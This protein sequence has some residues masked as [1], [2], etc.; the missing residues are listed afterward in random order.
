MKDFGK[1][2]I[3]AGGPSSERDISIESGKAVHRVLKAGGFDTVFIDARGTLEH[4]ISRSNADIVFI[5]LHGAF[6]EDGTVQKILDRIGMPYTGSGPDASELAMDKEASRKVFQDK[7]IN[8]PRYKV[9]KRGQRIDIGDLKLPL[10]V[11]PRREGSSIGLST[12]FD[13]K[14]L[15]QAAEKAF[16]YDEKILIEEFI[17]GR[18]L[19]V[20]I[21]DDKPL[22]V[23]EILPENGCYDYYAKYKSSNTKYLVPA[24][25]SCKEFKEAKA[26]GL[27]AHRALGCKSFS[28]VD[29]I[30]D[31]QGRI[32]I[33]E[34]N[35]IPG[36]T[37]RSLLPKAAEAAGISFL[38]LCKKILEE[39]SR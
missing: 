8:V 35:T 26:I 22:P 23:I 28:R 32:N 33:L 31:E 11:K 16:S 6:G 5:A 24:P 17:K 7:G 19:T 36:L 38:D 9:F 1:I 15:K 39:A 3:L 10:V 21:L 29:M 12:V 27:K 18:E 37:S 20:G 2:A 14:D 4:K 13:I 34:V 25:V 30:L